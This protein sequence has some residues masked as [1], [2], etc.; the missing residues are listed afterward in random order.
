MESLPEDPTKFLADLE[1]PLF[2]VIYIHFDELSTTNNY[3]CFLQ[4]TSDPPIVAIGEGCTRD[5]AKT[6]AAFDAINIFTELL[7][8]SC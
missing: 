5:A 2:K 1:D 8:V 4:I 6:S 7:A 3:Q